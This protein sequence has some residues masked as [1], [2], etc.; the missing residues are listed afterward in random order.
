[1]KPLALAIG[2]PSGGATREKRAAMGVVLWGSL[3]PRTGR[4]I[5]EWSFLLGLHYYRM[6]EK[7]EKSKHESANSKLQIYNIIRLKKILN[8][9]IRQRNRRIQEA[10][11]NHGKL[12][13]CERI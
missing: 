2:F 4:I 3:S 8:I 7:T 6:Y 1:M 10:I 11:Q 5:F 9:Q 12:A 13:I